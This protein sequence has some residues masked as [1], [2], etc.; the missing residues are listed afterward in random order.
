MLQGSQR[1]PR[2]EREGSERDRERPRTS[3]NQATGD[4]GLVDRVSVCVDSIVKC[5]CLS[6]LCVGSISAVSLASPP[7]ACEQALLFGRVKRVSRERANERRRLASLAQ[8]GE[9]ARRLPRR[10]PLGFVCHAFISGRN[11]CVT[12]EPQR[13]SAGRLPSPGSGL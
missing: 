3:E 12:N 4:D 5:V 10:R 2:R 8:I 7:I 9:L 11:E 1:S 13:T 6:A